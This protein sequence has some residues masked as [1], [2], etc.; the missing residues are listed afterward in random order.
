MEKF[1]WPQQASI[2][3]CSPGVPTSKGS[4]PQSGQQNKT[5]TQ[6][7]QL[8]CV[9][10]YES[11]S[12]PASPG[13]FYWPKAGKRKDRVLLQNPF[14]EA[15]PPRDWEA[16]VGQKGFQSCT[17]QVSGLWPHLPVNFS[18]S[19]QLWAGEEAGLIRTQGCR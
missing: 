12:L 17:S 8:E 3:N 2:S 11:S 16:G 14:L 18:L 10:E 6:Q 19:P 5:N 13:H 1:V 9:L 15:S 4:R 7:T